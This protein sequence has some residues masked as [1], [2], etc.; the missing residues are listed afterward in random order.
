MISGLLR[1]LGSPTNT[2]LKF[3]ALQL[4]HTILKGHEIDSL[5]S[6]LSDI[7]DKVIG[8][9]GALDNYF[10]VSAQSLRVLTVITTMLSK[11][12]D[13]R[14]DT[15]V[16]QIFG[17]VSQRFSAQ[18]IDQEVKECAVEAMCTLMAHFGPGVLKDDVCSVQDV[19]IDRLGNETIPGHICEAKS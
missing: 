16:R 4:L 14:C 1:C 3:E 2:T 5:Q 11:S 18:D 8:K 17:A 7:L 19:L 13:S 12:Q 9:D 6:H 15:F 10:R